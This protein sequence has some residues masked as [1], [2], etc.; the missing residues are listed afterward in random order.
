[1]A[2]ICKICQKNYNPSKLLYPCKIQIFLV[3]KTHDYKNFLLVQWP[4]E[5]SLRTCTW[6]YSI[7]SLQHWSRLATFM[8]LDLKE[9]SLCQNLTYTASLAPARSSAQFLQTSHSYSWAF[10]P[11][12]LLHNTV[13]LPHSSLFTLCCCPFHRT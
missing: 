4:L 9:L 13:L 5:T 7:D 2:L 1:M 6:E 10:H 3:K 8:W 12:S 11:L